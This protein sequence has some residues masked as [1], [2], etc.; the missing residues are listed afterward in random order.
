MKKQILNLFI[1]FALL[2]FS[3]SSDDSETPMNDPTPVLT[4]FIYENYNTVSEPNIVSIRKTYALENNKIISTT[5]EALE[6]GYTSNRTYTYI[7]GKVSEISKFSSGQLVEKK[8]FT[9]DDNSNLIEYQRE[10]SQSATSPAYFSKQSF[11]HSQDTIYGTSSRSDDGI[12][13][14]VIASNKVVLD[15]NLNSIFSEITNELNEETFRSETIFD[16]N[17][18]PISSST[19]EQLDN[20]EFF[21][22]LTHT[23]TYD[24][25]INPL[26]LIYEAT[27]GRQV[28]MLTSQHID[29]SSAI[30]NYN[31]K[32]ISANTFATFTS[33]FFG[34]GN[35]TTEFS[36]VYNEDNYSTFS[37][38]KFSVDNNLFTRFTYEFI[39]E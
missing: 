28:L 13:Y 15:V 8:M 14:E 1:F 6:T 29:N 33:T 18:N 37:D 7:N 12:D 39:F 4:E 30:N 21:N 32:Y 34:N 24:S 10:L 16:A 27:F 19:Y 38:F 5:H 31:A 23:Y 35:F 17:N 3:C 36:N 22:I 11:I 20:G 9:Y 26:A 25:G 2:C